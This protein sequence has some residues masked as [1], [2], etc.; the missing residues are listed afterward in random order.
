MV[1]PPEPI[2][3]PR[4][5]LDL[6]TLRIDPASLDE[7][8]RDEPVALCRVA[9]PPSVPQPGDARGRVAGPALVVAAPRPDRGSR[10]ERV[11]QLG[12]AISRAF[13][14]FTNGSG[15][16]S[17]L[18]PP[19]PIGVGPNAGFHAHTGRIDSQIDDLAFVCRTYHHPGWYLRISGVGPRL[20]PYRGSR[21]DCPKRRADP[22]RSRSRR[23]RGA[24]ES[25]PWPRRPAAHRRDAGRS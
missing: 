12:R 15:D 9:S 17:R 13:F 1:R 11:G 2:R 4:R 7:R 8:R 20:R 24:G 5:R 10:R 23:Q 16:K 18:E 25:L 22:G 3:G 14:S 6:A 21:R 19:R